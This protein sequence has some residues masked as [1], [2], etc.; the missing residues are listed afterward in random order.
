MRKTAKRTDALD[1]GLVVVRVITECH[2]NLDLF[3][4]RC[5][6]RSPKGIERREIYQRP[7]ICQVIQNNNNIKKE[8]RTMEKNNKE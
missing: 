1:S 7:D 5:L 4:I 6:K 8:M 2:Q 3:L